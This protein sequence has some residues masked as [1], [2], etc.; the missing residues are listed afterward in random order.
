[1]EP[2]GLEPATSCLQIRFGGRR[3]C[4]AAFRSSVFAGFGGTAGVLS[5]RCVQ[6]LLS[7]CLVPLA[8]SASTHA[9]SRVRPQ[10]MAPVLETPPVT[11]IR[12]EVDDA[13]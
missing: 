10:D 12:R 11:T 13:Q 3:S 5:G 4:A 1:M 7:S 2:A 8:T 9:L 6:Q